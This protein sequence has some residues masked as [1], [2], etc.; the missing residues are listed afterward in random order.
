MFLPDGGVIAETRKELAVKTYRHTAA[1]DASIVSWLDEDP[2]PPTLQ[3]SAERAEIL[4]YG[5][6]PH[7]Q[8]AFY[9]ESNPAE[10]GI[11]TAT[12]LQGKAL[13][14]NNI[15]D[16]DAALE[17]VKQFSDGPA[18]VIVKHAN[19]CGVAYGC[20]DRRLLD[21]HRHEPVLAVYDKVRR[22]RERQS[23]HADHV[24]DQ[25]VGRG[26]SEASDRFFS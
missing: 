8:A 26:R 3:L 2:L 12:Q 22:Y 15:A 9:V 6:N 20:D 14:Y 17:C 1:Y 18:C 23:E 24:L 7:Q 25:L 13:S 19:P 10:A 4:R 21:H 11:S 5:E 16:T